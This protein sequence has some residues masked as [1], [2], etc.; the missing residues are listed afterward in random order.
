MR[1][2]RSCRTSCLVSG[3]SQLGGMSSGLLCAASLIGLACGSSPRHG[4]AE[5][6]TTP[7]APA[8][9]SDSSAV[10]STSDDV[11]PIGSA[12]NEGVNPDLPLDGS[13]T[14]SP[15]GAAASGA[16]ALSAV[17]TL[18]GA[19][20]AWGPVERNLSNG[21][22][23]AGDGGPLSL[24]NQLYTSGLG[25]HAPSDVSFALAGDCTS[26]SADVGIDDEMKNAGA[27]SFQVWGDGALLSETG[28]L[29]GADAVQ[30][31][32][33]DVTGVDQLRLVVD[34]GDGNGSDHADWANAQV[35]CGHT[36]AACAAA[37]V[38]P[39]P[40]PG[41][42]L[43]WSDEFDVDGAPN[44]DN[45]SFEKGFV[46][47]E[48]AQWYQP[49]NAS[50]QSGFLII[51]GR[52]ERVANPNYR[53]G[54]TDWKTN[55]QYAE[56]TSAS[57]QSRGKQSFQFGRLEMRARFP[58]YQGL[59]PAWWM[60]GTTGGDWPWNG[61][62]DIL[63]FYAASLHAN[64]V[65]G[66]NTQWQGNWNAVATPLT[67]LGTADWDASFHVY[68]MDWTDTHI[69]LSVDGTTLNQLDLSSLRNPDGTSPFVNPEYT[70][71][72]LAIGGQAGGDPS[73]VPFP[74]RYEV[75]YV[76]VYQLDQ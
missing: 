36:L 59:W 45:W 76:R 53:A 56:Y 30:S 18:D 39:A 50:V 68:Q 22:D 65:V 48:E 19:Q 3:S 46:R 17:C 74:A 54:S 8:A 25:V 61:E 67:K 44:P 4:S 27:V 75:D 1:I 70:V 34:P 32:A 58:A 64:F 6:S 49:D 23:Q 11:S 51:E 12:S 28:V 60:L 55:R 57:L 14:S 43:V 62:I 24:A 5:F 31:L 29:T 38:V 10:P 40:V 66:T 20:N 52:R 41:Y 47:N 42:H 13:G 9:G 26:F 33:V 37:P 2:Q 16:Q 69:T 21:E 35:L 63:E 72:N 15:G 71:L 7:G 73:N